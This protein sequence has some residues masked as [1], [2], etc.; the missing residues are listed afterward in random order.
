[1]ENNLI[2]LSEAG[3]FIQQFQLLQQQMKEIQEALCI[4][5]TAV[6]PATP[7]REDSHSSDSSRTMG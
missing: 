1:M 7:A 5:L 2:A 4:Q 3:G 6:S